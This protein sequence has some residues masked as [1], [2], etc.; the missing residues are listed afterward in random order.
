M[1]DS[2]GQFPREPLRYFGGSMVTKANRRKEAL[3]D[4]GKTPGA[5]TRYFAKL[6]PAGLVPVKGIGAPDD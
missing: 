6:A 2:V 1:R 3:E 5:L 4:Q